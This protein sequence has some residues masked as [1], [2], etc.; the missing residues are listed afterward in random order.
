LHHVLTVVHLVPFHLW[1]QAPFMDW[2][3]WWKQ[4]YSG[5]TKMKMCPSSQGG[6]HCKWGRFLVLSRCMVLWGDCKM[7]QWLQWTIVETVSSLPPQIYA[8]SL[9]GQ[10]QLRRGNSQD[11]QPKIQS[12]SKCSTDKCKPRNVLWWHANSWTK[13]PEFIC[14]WQCPHIDCSTCYL[15][16]SQCNQG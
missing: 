3:W 10:L 1:E 5:Q 8:H 15:Y 11:G 2:W 12:L 16:V 14:S 13:W 7:G 6:T 9:T 4:Q